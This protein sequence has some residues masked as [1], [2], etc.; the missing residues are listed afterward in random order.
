L[1]EKPFGKLS[2]GRPTKRW[3]ENFNM[4]LLKIGMGGRTGSGSF[5]VVSYGF[6]DI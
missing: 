2:L 3:E 5:P 1:V 4:V 6:S